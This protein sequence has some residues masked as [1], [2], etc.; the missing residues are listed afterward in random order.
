MSRTKHVDIKYQAMKNLHEEG[1]I[2][3]IYFPTNQMVVDI[4]TKPLPKADFLKH[5]SNLL[6]STDSTFEG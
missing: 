4:M 5:R 1:I 3:L 2:E 6:E